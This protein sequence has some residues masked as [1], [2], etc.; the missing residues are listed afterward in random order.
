MVIDDSASTRSA[1][2]GVLERAGHE[3]AAVATVAEGLG[4]LRSRPFDL[5]LV[6][7]PERGGFDALKK[8]RR[9][10]LL[11]S[12]PI[13]MIAVAPTRE[14]IIEAGR[15]G[16]R[17]VV[18]L[19]QDYERKLVERVGHIVSQMQ[20]AAAEKS[21]KRAAGPSPSGGRAALSQPG[22]QTGPQTAAQAASQSVEDGAPEHAAQSNGAS[23]HGSGADRVH[24]G[25][26]SR[27]AAHA[28]AHPDQQPWSPDLQL[29]AHE[30]ITM[31]HAI[32]SLKEMKPIISRSELLDTMLQESTSLRAMRPTAQQ[33][34]QLTDRPDS[35]VQAVA[36]ALRKDQA[37]SIHILKLANS[38]LYGRS[39][40]ISNI[41]KAVAR[42]G[43]G[44][45]KNA[46]LSIEVLDAF[47]SIEL[48]HI[49]KPAWFWEHSI[50]CGLIANRCAEATSLAPD[51]AET[52]FTAGLLHDIGR[53]IL[54]EQLPNHYPKV[55]SVA[56]RLRL[57]LEYVE[58][59]LLLMN[60]A[61]I[62]DRVLRHW[63]FPPSIVTP[64]SMH[65]LAL[66]T[67]RQSAPRHV[68]AVLPLSIAN[69][70]AHALILGSS[71]N[72]VIYPLEDLVEHARIEPSTIGRICESVVSDVADMSASFFMHAGKSGGS[73][74][75][76][77]RDALGEARPVA[78]SLQ[79]DIDPT[80]IM[81]ERISGVGHH[82][83]PNLYILR[84]CKAADRAPVMQL[85]EEAE[86]EQRASGGPLL[87]VLVVGNAQS[88]LFAQGS[89]GKRHVCQLT[90]PLQLDRILSEI[91]M[92][93][94]SSLQAA[95]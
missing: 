34:L 36:E 63:N 80:R 44:Q 81:L 2:A 35:S 7:M 53:L 30:P 32:A 28:S 89:L 51:V 68:D 71:G 95:A 8:I 23:G 94:A 93:L 72:N 83:D 41:H 4:L 27:I 69:R 38:A 12:I 11:A 79:P 87:P 45:I 15:L 78:L 76:T 59:R 74:L 5:L 90:L 3:I 24:A 57:P 82:E 85:L 22:L 20:G 62:T 13:L 21:A 66:N 39:E 10:R 92:L 58:S 48:S 55:V 16:V 88:C 19:D 61:D 46:V 60:H 17:G 75:D 86:A 64:V 18:I 67:L 33:V 84:V 1:A 42:I 73:Y 65:H 14:S 56:E 77:L 54:A 26:G 70:L 91:R 25:D 50:A 40:A 43:M 29:S 37:L 47:G 6:E 49:I 9:D 31:D 52:M